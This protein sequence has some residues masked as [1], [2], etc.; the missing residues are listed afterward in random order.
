MGRKF[1]SAPDA[2]NPEWTEETFERALTFDQLPESLRRK[3]QS[4]GVRKNRGVAQT[5][6]IKSLKDWL[7]RRR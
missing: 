5:R 7:Q 2:D 4:I 3:L 1:D 6:E